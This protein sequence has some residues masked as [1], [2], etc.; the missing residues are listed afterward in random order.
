ME[1]KEQMKH[2]MHEDIQK[3]QLDIRCKYQIW[4]F[5]FFGLSTHA[6]QCSN[7]YIYIYR[8]RNTMSST[9]VELFSGL[10]TLMV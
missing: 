5:F 1:A 8:Y 4:N 10:S 2:E 9:S 7:I 3:P 6:N